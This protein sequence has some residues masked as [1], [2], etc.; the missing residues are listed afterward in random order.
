MKKPNTKFVGLLLVGIL[1]LVVTTAMFFVLLSDN[2]ILN[3][4]IITDIENRATVKDYS[5]NTTYIKS[6][7]PWPPQVVVKEGVWKCQVGEGAVLGGGQS[8]E[9]VI[10]VSDYCITT[11]REGA[12]GSTYSTYEY[13]TTKSGQLATM[14]F[15]LQYPQCANYV[16]PQNSE[17][18]DEQDS[19]DLDTLV[20]AVIMK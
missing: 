16:S 14:N 9:K 18:K 12:A 2:K 6:L 1:A 7:S 19:F 10:G 4:R 20:N 13:T 5:L 3:L 17:C 15:V 11:T 8:V